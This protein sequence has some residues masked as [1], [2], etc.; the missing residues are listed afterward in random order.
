MTLVCVA[1]LV[2][3]DWILKARWPGVVTGKLSDVTGLAFAPVVLS[4]AIGLVLHAAARLGARV[5]PS[6]SRRRLYACCAATAAGFALVK[7]CA[8]VR[9]LAARLIGHGAEFYPDWTDVLCL[10]AV[11]IALWIGLDE[12][13][14]IPLGRPSAIHRLG[15]PAAAALA[16]TGTDTTALAAAID[17]WDVAAIDRELTSLANPTAARADRP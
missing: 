4:A 12:L 13:R 16:D 7:L 17:R 3:N 2:V 6:L 14:R 1:L 5:D 11:L 8:P 9:E 10:P 15:R